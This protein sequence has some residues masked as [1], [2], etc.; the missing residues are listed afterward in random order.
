MNAPAYDQ[1]DE[2]TREQIRDVLMDAEVYRFVDYVGVWQDI[3]R[4]QLAEVA[5]NYHAGN[6]EIM[7]V[8]DALGEIETGWWGDNGS[9]ERHVMRFQVLEDE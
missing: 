2:A 6:D 8:L 7:A 1:T 5:M 3:E 9:D 4:Q